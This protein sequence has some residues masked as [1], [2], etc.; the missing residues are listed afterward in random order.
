MRR[1]ARGQLGLELSTRSNAVESTARFSACERYRYELTR[2][3]DSAAT[4]AAFVLLNPSTADAHRN[5]PTVTRCINFARAWGYGG[6]AV[7]NIFAWRSTDP[8]GLRACEDPVGPDNDTALI[9][10]ARRARIV[11]CGWGVHGWLHGRG[12]IV[13]ALLERE[14]VE[15]HVLGRTKDGHPRHPLYLPS[16]AAPEA[17]S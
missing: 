8:A 10:I 11:V 16:D 5:D 4:L 7:G 17:W 9:E 13:R 2:V 1:T 3:W 14:G 6:L 15:L 12:T